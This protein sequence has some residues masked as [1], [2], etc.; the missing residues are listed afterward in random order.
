[1]DEQEVKLLLRVVQEEL[2]PLAEWLDRADQQK[3]AALCRK[4]I[5]QVHSV[6]AYYFE[7][8]PP[9]G[10]SRTKCPLKR[11]DCPLKS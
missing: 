4:A 9:G 11:S 3:Y 2:T 10:S 1:M 7:A 6:Q 8:P 5:D